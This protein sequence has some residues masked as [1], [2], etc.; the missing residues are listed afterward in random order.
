MRKFGIVGVVQKPCEP[1]ELSITIERATLYQYDV[2]L[3]GGYTKKLQK[4]A[5]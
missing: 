4:K 3:E 1:K 2:D 5:G